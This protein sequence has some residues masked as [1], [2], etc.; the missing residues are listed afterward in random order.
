MQ[1]DSSQQVKRQAIHL[2]HSHSMSMEMDG[3]FHA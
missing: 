1:A 3:S 2:A